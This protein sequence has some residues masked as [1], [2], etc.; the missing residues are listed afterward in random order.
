MS[1][2]H[3]IKSSAAIVSPNPALAEQARASGQ[4]AAARNHRRRR[5]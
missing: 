3:A 4:P 2:R 1:S 5:G